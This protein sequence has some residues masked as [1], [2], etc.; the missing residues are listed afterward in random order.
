MNRT[1][2]IAL[3]AERGALRHTPAGL[4]ALDLWLE[5]Q[6]Q[7]EEAGQIRQVQL[8]IRALALGGVAERLATQALGSQWR[9]MGFLAS[10]R[11]RSQVIFHIQD[12]QTESSL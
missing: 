9:F 2:L 4:P 12:F 8:R 3:L 5:H 6:S 11:Q 1:E 7:L 10:P